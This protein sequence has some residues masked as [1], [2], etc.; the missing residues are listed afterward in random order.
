[1]LRIVS[2]VPT[3]VSSMDETAR[4]RWIASQILPFESEVRGWLTAYA[5][6]LDNGDIEEIG[7]EAFSRL[8]TTN[9]TSIVNARAHFFAVVRSLIAERARQ[10]RIVPLQRMGEIEALRVIG[11][12]PGPERA[13][14]TRRQIARLLKIVGRMPVQCRRVFKLRTFE[15]LS[16][17]QIAEAAGLSEDAVARQLAR[18]LSRVMS[19]SNES[20][21]TARLQPAAFTSGRSGPRYGRRR[22]RD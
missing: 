7:H 15:G 5:T 10:A 12:E 3:Q 13:I 17:R 8:W 6:T 18:A 2:K 22:R 20:V 9:L 21:R 4:L 1:V 11:E 19:A 14:G 16:Q